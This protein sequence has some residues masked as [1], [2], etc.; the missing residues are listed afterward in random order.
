MEKKLRLRSIPPRTRPLYPTIPRRATPNIH[1]K[2]TNSPS[3]QE[4]ETNWKAVVQ[5]ENVFRQPPPNRP[6]T[7]ETVDAERR[8]IGLIIETMDNWNSKKDF[9][10]ILSLEGLDLSRVDFKRG[11]GD[12]GTDSSVFYTPVGYNGNP[13][14]LVIGTFGDVFVTQVVPQKFGVNPFLHDERVIEELAAC[15][16]TSMKVSANNG[17]FVASYRKR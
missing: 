17:I 15:D 5:R 16:P 9:G 12:Y 10:V 1:P 11:A 14:A 3:W 6:K 7:A 4:G 8:R 2:T 13:A